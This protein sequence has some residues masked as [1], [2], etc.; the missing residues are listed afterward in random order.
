MFE[1]VIANFATKYLASVSMVVPKSFDLTSDARGLS[2]K[3]GI[4]VHLIEVDTVTNGPAESAFLGLEHLDDATPIVIANSDQF[5]DFS[6]QVWI[7]SVMDSNA[8][9][10][11]LC[12]RDNDPKWS[13]ARVGIDG[14]AKEVVEKRVI[15]DLAT[16]GVYFF[17]SSQTFKDGFL[18]VVARD[19]RVNGEF[20]VAP[21]YNEAINDGKHFKIYDVDEFRTS[22]LDNKTTDDKVLICK[23]LIN[24][25]GKEIIRVSVSKILIEG[26]NGKYI[27]SYI[28]RDINA[29]KNI[30]KIVNYGLENNLKRPKWYNRNE[31]LPVS[32]NT[33]KKVVLK[34]LTKKNT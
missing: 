34:M 32:K 17:R 3:L 24:K 1:V 18:D 22:K 20:Y 21:V 13:Y 14:L 4:P 28:N 6:P 26:S 29:C 16:C 33:S 8:A 15:S 27:K 31:K 11:I 19:E 23:N 25:V 30:R 10:S 9:G 7:D 2:E 5:L 12:M